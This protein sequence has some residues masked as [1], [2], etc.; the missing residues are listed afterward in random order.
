MFD[1]RNARKLAGFQT[2]IHLSDFSTVD[3][4]SISKYESNK[5]IPEYLNSVILALV[6]KKPYEEFFKTIDENVSNDTLHYAKLDYEIDK[7]L[8]PILLNISRQ[9]LYNNESLYNAFQDLLIN[10]NITEY[11]KTKSA[12]KSIIEIFREKKSFCVLNERTDESTYDYYSEYMALRLLTYMYRNGSRENRKNL[13]NIL[14]KFVSEYKE[15]VIPN[16]NMAGCVELT[17]SK[18][19]ISIDGFELTD[20]EKERYIEYF[21]L[22]RRL[23]TSRNKEE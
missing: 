18:L 14:T 21:R 15:V 11:D 6:F 13:F 1:F 8:Y 12:A 4:T 20:F 23:M 17:D 7:V 10:Q 5:A 22:D 19:R 2:Q 16:Q 3:R 9:I